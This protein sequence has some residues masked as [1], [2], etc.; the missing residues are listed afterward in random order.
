MATNDVT[1]KRPLW[2]LI[3]DKILEHGPRD[4]EGENKE[5]TVQQIAQQLDEAGHKVSRN[6]GHL[7]QLR[8]AIQDRVE[9]GRPLMQDFNEAIAALALEDVADPR[10][11]AA[12]L[13]AEV[14]ATWP[15]L[16]RSERKPDI[17]RILEKTKLDLLIA[18]A[19]GL[20]EDDG[21]RLLI[22]E[23]VLPEVI[24]AALGISD[25]KFG[26]VNAA[27]EAERAERVRVEE[28]LEGVA[29]RSTDDKVKHLLTNDVAPSLIVE[30]MEID[31]GV[32]DGVKQ[33]MEAE[34]EEKQRLAEEAAAKKAA[35]AAGPALDDIP[36]D[37]MLEHIES[38]REILE[39]SDQEKEIRA[40]CEQSSIPKSLVDIAVSD[41]DKLDALEEQHGG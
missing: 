3:E 40:M 27:M 38:I 19:K 35:E 4:F 5:S 23:E 2:L 41:P 6:G 14:G 18:K 7:L 32:V 15:E 28:L 39:F 30:V 24:S 12:N 17:L 21:I 1:Q 31:Q 13:T 10:R 33:A 22:V 16:R 34:L 25:E 8:W 29:D 37:E 11:T 26:Q 36:S 20:S 9:V